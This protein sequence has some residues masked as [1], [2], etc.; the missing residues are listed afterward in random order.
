LH[1]VLWHFAWPSLHGPVSG[2]PGLCWYRGI[3]NFARWHHDVQYDIPSG[4]LT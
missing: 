4:N 3:R 2:G 1:L